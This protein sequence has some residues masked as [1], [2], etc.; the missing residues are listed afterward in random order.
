M[1]SAASSAGLS[2][3]ALLTRGLA[4]GDEEAF[5][6]FH[7]EYFDRL[8]RYHLVLARGD[9]QAARDALQETLGRVAR[10]TK[11]FACEHAFWNWLALLAR[12]AAIDG[13]RRRQRYWAFLQNYTA[14]WFHSPPASE[15][16]HE[17]RLHE[18]LEQGLASLPP[19][20]RELIEAKYFS[21]ATVRGLA[22]QA[23]LTEKA[24]ES[25]LRRLRLRL[26]EQLVFLLRDERSH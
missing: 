7:A 25:R 24:M 4:A 23:G 22:Q 12:C 20:E 6:R 14:S 1:Q 13:G 5:R 2:P 18:L 3:T 15:P 21:G 16:D 11:Q 19:D 8:L 26:R 17:A 9:E 10:K